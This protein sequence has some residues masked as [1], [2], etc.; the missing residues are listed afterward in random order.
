[1]VLNGCSELRNREL[2]FIKVIIYS[3]WFRIL[4][5]PSF[6]IPEPVQGTCAYIHAN[7]L[8]AC[9]PIKMDCEK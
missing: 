4:E 9:F 6:T 2:M 1:M 8:L 5:I 7:V 3:N